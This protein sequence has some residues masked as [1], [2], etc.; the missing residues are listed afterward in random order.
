MNFKIDPI[1]PWMPSNIPAPL[2]SELIRRSQNISFNYIKD[3]SIN[4][5]QWIRKKIE[6]D[7]KGILNK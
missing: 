1:I 3:K 2:K 6:N 7:R 4:L 5:S